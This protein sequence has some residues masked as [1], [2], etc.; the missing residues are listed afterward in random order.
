MGDGVNVA[1][2]LEG[3]CRAGRVCLSEDAYRQVKRGSNSQVTDL[4]PTNLKN[5]AEPVR[6]YSLKSAS[7]RKRTGGGESAQAES[8][9][10]AASARRLAALAGARRRARSR[11]SRSGRFCLACGLRAA[12]SGRFRREDKLA[13]APR[14]S[15]VVL[16]FENLSGDKEQDYFADGIT[17]DLTTDLSHLP[18]SFVIARDTAFTYKGKPVDAKQIGRELGVRY[19]LEGSV[20][21]VGETITVNAQLIST[22]T[23]AHV[24]ADRFDGER[25]KLGE[26]Q[27]EF[28]SR[29]ANSLGVELVKAESL[30]AM[31][32]RPNNPDAVDLAMRAASVVDSSDKSKLGRRDE[33]VRARARS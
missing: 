2:R 23:G 16:P 10:Y 8:D 12:L 17:D 33:P 13:T 22:E 21:R 11:A 15:I 14:L 1:A 3:I 31:R 25:S 9:A 32:E 5:I 20:R 29:L 30:R 28:V 27:V 4:G 24:W 6:A 18:D 26:L 7:R 19:V